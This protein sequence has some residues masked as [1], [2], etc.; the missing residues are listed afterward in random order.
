MC[1]RTGYRPGDLEI[2]V[3][4]SRAGRD[5]DITSAFVCAGSM[6]WKGEARARGG[7]S[8]WPE[9]DLFEYYFGRDPFVV[10]GIEEVLA[11]MRVGGRVH[12]VVPSRLGFCVQQVPHTRTHSHSLTH[13]HAGTHTDRHTQV[14]CFSRA[15]EHRA[16]GMTSRCRRKT[17]S[18][19]R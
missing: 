1:T 13:F 15:C 11:C 4:I 3:D 19:M 9:D 17:T 6:P 12:C 14:R 7:S 16:H 5:T 8:K 18:A 10:P 2:C